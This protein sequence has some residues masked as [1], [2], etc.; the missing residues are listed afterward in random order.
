MVHGWARHRCLG[1]QPS[2]R[3]AYV[4]FY[5]VRVKVSSFRS[6]LTLNGRELAS[7]CEMLE[8]PFWQKHWE[9]K[10]V[11]NDRTNNQVGE[12]EKKEKGL[13]IDFETG[14]GTISCVWVDASP[15]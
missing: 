13:Q 9:G 7:E 8:L 4:T 12:W 5:K 14:R 15:R 6:A 3:L 1:D 2:K 10:E 11:H